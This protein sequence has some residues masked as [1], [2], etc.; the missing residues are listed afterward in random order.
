MRP[1]LF[2]PTDAGR[3]GLIRAQILVALEGPELLLDGRRPQ[4]AVHHVESSTEWD[5][6]APMNLAAHSSQAG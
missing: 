1:R 3:N 6:D 4:K 2:A 5:D